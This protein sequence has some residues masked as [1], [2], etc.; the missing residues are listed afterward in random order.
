M[1]KNMEYIYQIYKEGGFSQAAQKLYVSQPAISAIVRRTEQQLGLPLF[2]RSTSPVRPTEDGLYYIQCIERIR[3]IEEEM[4]QYFEQR[5]SCDHGALSVGSGTYYCA[6][7]LPGMIRNFHSLHPGIQISQVESSSTQR[8]PLLLQG[9]MDFS[10]DVNIIDDPTLTSIPIA[11]EHILLAVP[12]A[13]ACNDKLRYCRLTMADIRRGVHL[14]DQFPVAEMAAFRDEPFVMLKPGNHSHDLLQQLCRLGGFEPN[15]ALRT[16]QMLTAYYIAC[17]GT[18]ITIVRDSSLRHVAL[19]SNLY[20]YRLPKGL[21]SRNI[22]LT[23]L[24]RSADK[25]LV[26][27]F[28]DYVCSQIDRYSNT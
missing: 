5:T 26:R 9:Q 14:D 7:L 25:P 17:E 11:R 3:A 16:D 13:F 2:D 8:L 4:A 10:I 21:D 12:A 23:Y 6:Y 1:N 28:R 22:F 27:L 15:I 24:K 18:G 19:S 20:Y